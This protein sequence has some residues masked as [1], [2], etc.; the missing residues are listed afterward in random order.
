MSVS[1]VPR[2]PGA[3]TAAFSIPFRA[4]ISARREAPPL[5]VRRTVLLRRSR[6]P[7]ARRAT[8]S[9]YWGYAVVNSL[10]S[11]RKAAVIAS[12]VAAIFN[13]ASRC[14]SGGTSRKAR[15]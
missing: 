4:W 1:G 10:T 12:I 15:N 11:A 6:H 3:V 5:Q 13:T 8:D 14:S 7:Q 2:T 9:E